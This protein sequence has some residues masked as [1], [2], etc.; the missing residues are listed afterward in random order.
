MNCDSK[1]L[2][3]CV[4]VVW[5]LACRSKAMLQV[6]ITEE[7]N[8]VKGQNIT[9]ACNVK[10]ENK[11]ELLYVKVT[12]FKVKRHSRQFLQ[13]TIAFEE[14]A[15]KDDFYVTLPNAGP[16]TAGRYMC[17][18]VIEYTYKTKFSSSSGFG[19]VRYQ[20]KCCLH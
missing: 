9:L 20:G 16:Y 4:A 5:S 1:L 11:K 12:F 18:V 17:E 13:E 10:A 14:Y 15:R 6:E 3:T 7:T 8:A 19:Y 2:C